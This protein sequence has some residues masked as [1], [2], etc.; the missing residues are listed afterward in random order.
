[1]VE[2]HSVGNLIRPNSCIDL[3]RRTPIYLYATPFT[4]ATIW[5]IRQAQRH[6]GEPNS[7]TDLAGGLARGNE[8]V[9]AGTSPTENK[10]T[11]QADLMLDPSEASI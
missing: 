5:S 11:S 7:E 9:L 1:M 6:D 8:A 2:D 10:Q 4:L 3:E